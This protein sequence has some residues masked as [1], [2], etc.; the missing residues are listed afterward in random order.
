[1]SASRIVVELGDV[2]QAECLN[3]VGDASREAASYVR[4]RDEMAP[5][6]HAIPY[7]AHASFRGIQTYKKKVDLIS[8]RLGL[9]Q[10]V[11]LAV[12]SESRF[13]RETNSL[14]QI[15]GGALQRLSPGGKVI[16]Y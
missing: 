2:R 4:I 11:Q 7:A 12:A 9:V 6:C 16:S 8:S 14:F 1:M 15:F 3:G 5:V 10:Q 13:Y